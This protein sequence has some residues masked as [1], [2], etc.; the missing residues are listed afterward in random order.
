[1]QQYILIG[2]SGHGKVIADC[3]VSSGGEIIAKLDDKYIELFEEEAIVK[4]PLSLLPL[5]LTESVKVIISIGS[6]LIRK[7]I[8]ERLSI[9]NEQYATVIHKS[10]IISENAQIG[11]GTVVMPGAIINADAKVGNHCIVNT[12]AIVEHDNVLEDYVHI[13]PNVTLTGNV[14]VSEGTQ[15]GAASVVIPSVNVGEWSIIG[16]GS[17]VTKD[18]PSNI[19]AVGAP[20]KVIKKEGLFI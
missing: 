12:A 10:A 7:K 11:Y 16:A 2:D 6:N 19:T 8:V 5:L 15:V 18:L 4:G 14:H 20:A 3:I 17:T 9:S 1:M 13:S